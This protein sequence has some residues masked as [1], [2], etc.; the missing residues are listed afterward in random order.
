VGIAE[1]TLLAS[2]SIPSQ[3]MLLTVLSV[4]NSSNAGLSF[5]IS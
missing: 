2:G 4:A 1:T 5:A 3:R